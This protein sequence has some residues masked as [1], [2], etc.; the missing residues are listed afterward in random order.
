MPPPLDPNRLRNAAA[1]REAILEA[2]RRR[3]ARESYDE[4]G[5]RDIGGDA[6]VDAALVSR[7]FGSKE[8]LFAQVLRACEASGGLTDGDPA[9]FGQR[10]ARALVDG[11]GKQ[12]S[13]LEGLII[14]LQSAG[15]A[16]AREV[17]QRALEERLYAP[18]A[19]WLGGGEARVRARL[20][21][22]VIMGMA[23]S[24]VITGGYGLPPA[25]RDRL[26]QRLADLLQACVEG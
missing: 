1:T 2:A 7:Y 13:K 8:D 4:V 10:L 9:G 6:G 14:M 3:F 17:V 18:L 5:L 19:E 24:R 20:A 22:G 15:S 26:R 23:I 11:E 21:A 25:E 16:N 12:G